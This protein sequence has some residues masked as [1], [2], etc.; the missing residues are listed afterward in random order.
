MKI[1]RF[2]SQFLLLAMFLWIAGCA[3]HPDPLAGWQENFDPSGPSDKIIE[4]DYQDYIK[5]LGLKP[6]KMGAL[7]TYASENG[8]EFVAS[9]DFFKDGT[10]QHAVKITISLNH[11]VWEHVLIY[12]KDNK[13]IRTIKYRSGSVS[14]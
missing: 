14:C 7:V 9:T 2:T 8:N 10:G 3:T 6:I 5:G 12:D 1:T 4:K 13:R 11:A